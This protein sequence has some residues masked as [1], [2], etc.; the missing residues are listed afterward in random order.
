MTP[1]VF[2][3]IA[4]MSEDNVSDS[5]RTAIAQKVLDA[6]GKEGLR[7]L[8]LCQDYYD[9]TQPL[10]T[11]L[12]PGTAWWLQEANP[13]ADLI[14]EQFSGTDFDAA[15]AALK[16]ATIPPKVNVDMRTQ[17]NNQ[18][19]SLF[20]PKDADVYS[21]ADAKTVKAL[22]L[23]FFP[24]YPLLATPQCSLYLDVV[25]YDD[26]DTPGLYPAY[27][28]PLAAFADDAHALHYLLRVHQGI[29]VTRE[30]ASPSME[31]LLAQT[32]KDWDILDSLG[33][34]PE[35]AYHLMQ[36]KHASELN[37]TLPKE[38]AP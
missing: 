6:Q 12:T 22:A 37:V 24:Q 3:N 30:S 10:M 11:G 17:M 23:Q 2:N 7:T 28:E 20:V 8:W 18:H 27:N 34:D 35:N 25:E 33:V 19:M 26:E 32:D 16:T 15:L 36:S 14:R 21:H 29:T 9:P 38:F 5:E 1:I 4:R 13:Y 31:A